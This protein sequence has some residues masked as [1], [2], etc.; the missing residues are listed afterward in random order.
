M[1]NW[2]YGKNDNLENS[3]DLRNL[4]INFQ[5]LTKAPSSI[6]YD[7]AASFLCSYGTAYMALTRRANIK[8]GYDGVS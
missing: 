3:S 1:M 4:S 8:E 2:V 5:V 6:S 7:L